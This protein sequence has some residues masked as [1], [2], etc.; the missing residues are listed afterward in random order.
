MNYLFA[1]WAISQAMYHIF[2]PFGK[3]WF[4]YA[5][6]CPYSA[7]SFDSLG[8]VSRDLIRLRIKIGAPYRPRRS[9]KCF[10]AG[11]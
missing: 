11:V 8:T 6:H 10:A 4:K 3:N 1:A 2:F 7:S 5:T 9:S